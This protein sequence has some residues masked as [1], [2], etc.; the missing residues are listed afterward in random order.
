M[1]RVVNPASGS[2][3][4]GGATSSPPPD[5]PLPRPSD[6]VPAFLVGLFLPEP[7]TGREGLPAD[8]AAEIR[9]GRFDRAAE[10]L[11]AEAESEA[12]RQDRRRHRLVA[13]DCLL[14]AGRPERAEQLLAHDLPPEG[15]WSLACA[16]VQRNQLQAALESLASMARH[17]LLEG[18]RDA[19]A[20]LVAHLGVPNL[21]DGLAGLAAP[22]GPSVDDA[23]REGYRRFQDLIV[24]DI[25]RHE[26]M[27]EVRAIVSRSRAHCAAIPAE[28]EAAL[29][30]RIYEAAV[31][32]TF[33]AQL[34]GCG[35]DLLLEHSDRVTV[36]D[37]G[38]SRALVFATASG[39]LRQLGDRLL[40]CA[41]TQSDR[42]RCCRCWLTLAR[43]GLV[44]GDATAIELHAARAAALA[45]TAV[46]REAA[47]RLR[48]VAAWLRPR[49]ASPI[50]EWQLR[51][52][53]H[54][55]MPAVAERLDAWDRCFP[56][57][58]GRGADERSVRAAES[59]LE[60][61]IV[62]SRNRTIPALQLALGNWA[63]RVAVLMREARWPDI[64]ER[65]A[66]AGSAW[67]L[68]GP[69]PPAEVAHEL[70]DAIGVAHASL[71]DR[72]AVRSRL[73][74][75]IGTLPLDPAA[76]TG[77]MREALA[78]W[79]RR[80]GDG[81]PPATDQPLPSLTA[82]L[83]PVAEPPPPWSLETVAPALGPSHDLSSWLRQEVERC[84]IDRMAVLPDRP[85]FR[86]R[87]RFETEEAYRLYR[88][89]REERDAKARAK[90]FE[91]AWTQEPDNYIT[92]Q[93]V[94][95]GLR[96]RLEE[97]R[98]RR[99]VLERL[100]RILDEMPEREV[101]AAL[102]FRSLAE[103]SER[104][105]AEWR[106]NLERAAAALQHRVHRRSWPR[107]RSAQIALHLELGDPW[108][109]AEAAWEESCQWLPGSEPSSGFARLAAELWSRAQA[110]E[111]GTLDDRGRQAR[112]RAE[113]PPVTDREAVRHAAEVG[114]L[115][116]LSA[117]D[118]DVDALED[119]WRAC[120]G[121]EDLLTRFLEAQGTHR[122]DPRPHYLEF[123]LGKLDA[124]QP[125]KAVRIR[126]RRLGPSASDMPASMA[127]LRVAAA[128]LL[129]RDPLTELATPRRR[130]SDPLL[131]ALLAG[132]R[133]AADD[134]PIAC[135]TF[136][137]E[138]V[139]ASDALFHL[140]EEMPDV[141]PEHHAGHV[142]G[143]REAVDAAQRAAE[144]FSSPAV[145]S[146]AVVVS[147]HLGL[148]LD[149]SMVQDYV[150]EKE[151]R[152]IPSRLGLRLGS[153]HSRLRQS[154]GP[155]DF[156]H[157]HQAY[158]YPGDLPLAEWWESPIVHGQRVRKAAED[159]LASLQ[160]HQTLLDSIEQQYRETRPP[161]GRHLDDFGLMAPL[162]RSCQV[163]KHA[164]APSAGVAEVRLI[165]PTLKELG[166]ALRGCEVLRSMD[167]ERML[168]DGP[169]HTSPYLLPRTAGLF[170]HWRT[171]TGDETC[172]RAMFEMQDEE[173]QRFLVL[174]CL[175]AGLK[176]TPAVVTLQGL[177]P[178]ADIV[179][180]LGGQFHIWIAR[181]GET[182][183]C[184]RDHQACIAT[185][186]VEQML[187]R[188]HEVASTTW[189]SRR[190]EVENWMPIVERAL[191]S[192]QT[193]N[194]QFALLPRLHG[195]QQ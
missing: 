192:R 54:L 87:A 166:D 36:D 68:L 106:A 191:R 50:S 96:R 41:E 180:A 150:R 95:L 85:P 35:L 108:A 48:R 101:E 126:Q 12:S 49:A 155:L 171:N 61:A 131:R 177:A 29:L 161:Y 92:I 20:A 52:L 94:I 149:R 43:I 77:L 111:P 3:D 8:A 51:Q 25:G 57:A 118:L 59:A 64:E 27:A 194:L 83:R 21:P 156:F 162:A 63:H 18:R 179:E 4:A 170:T 84:L 73:D 30:A 188:L 134:D 116:M 186:Y 82:A 39:R 114:R 44:D 113:L 115:E 169:R 153:W 76:S 105:S 159:L 152:L 78:A 125:A 10:L 62:A 14:I 130:L 145:A 176:D 132:L 7:P 189:L 184:R 93:G 88:Q 127:Q 100:A 163:L 45:A 16:Q 53:H 19:A 102:A 98:L 23:K 146:M 97:Q 2:A 119:L 15:I 120:R 9:R 71:T 151:R 142:T 13:A 160:P 182:S 72:D 195:E 148:G 183:R 33:D 42:E 40:Q 175:D 46:Q 79:E 70:A 112:R 34:A 123:L 5:Q 6:R 31:R 158:E 167:G 193:A 80:C 22:A 164:L 66:Y 103:T 47:G 104:G 75:V 81:F 74:Y 38:A 174:I 135:A 17:G 32:A 109:A 140:V 11:L 124:T 178:F 26:D 141:E 172:F 117:H 24:T 1:T 60:A 86:G 147:R 128:E 190:G 138:V 110:D 69:N 173:G 133:E 187:F 144:A 137:T 157:Y 139:R 55:L 136:S 58:L 91:D 154:S 181:P 67:R 185:D 122:R 56:A 129:E 89:G 37:A 165:A 90:A 143:A 107:A 99:H 121:Q 168:V 65:V 28:D